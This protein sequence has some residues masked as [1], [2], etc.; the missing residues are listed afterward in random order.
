MRVGVGT[1]SYAGSCS[2]IPHVAEHLAHK[3]VDRAGV[4]P[5]SRVVQD[6]LQ[7]AGFR[8]VRLE[9]P[10]VVS[11]GDGVAPGPATLRYFAVQRAN[12]AANRHLLGLLETHQ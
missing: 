6:H 10:A 8:A 5:M 3:P 4:P 7:P 1:G 12:Q 2:S 11:V 9:N